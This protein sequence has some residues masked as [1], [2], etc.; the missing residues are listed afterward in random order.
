[1]EL[2][3]RTES[4]GTQRRLL[5][6]LPAFSPVAVRLLSLLAKEQVSFKDV[7]NL[8]SL[9]PV[10]SGEVLRLANSGLY[11]RRAE[12]DSILFA[13]AI[14]GCGK[15]SQIVVTA[16]L[17]RGLPHR[18]SPFIRDWWRH[19]IA[20]ALTARHCSEDSLKDSSYSAALLHGVGQLALF[21]DAPHDYCKL[22]EGAY[23]NKADLLAQEREAFGTDHASLAGLILE[24]WAL[25]ANLCEAVAK[26]HEDAG[27]GLGLAVRN[28]CLGAEFAG[29]GQCGCQQ[30]LASGIPTPM[31]EW[32]TGDYFVTLVAGVNGIECSLV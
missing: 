12:V 29:F 21:Q 31:S 20:S 16:A 28:A 11:G 3:L 17:W 22:V 15:L 10:L 9:D 7:A 1:M 18:T 13:I 30:A 32:F 2:K 14:L 4:N 8:I 24:S 23:A 19:S 6:R 25:P 26:H 5:G 27:P